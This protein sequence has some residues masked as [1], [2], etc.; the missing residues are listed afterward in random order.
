MRKL[1]VGQVVK[2]RNFHGDVQYERIF[3]IGKCQRHKNLNWERLTIKGRIP[4]ASNINDDCG[5]IGDIEGGLR[6]LSKK[7]RGE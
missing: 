3:E 1:K 2:F 5:C 4:N 6:P 7:E